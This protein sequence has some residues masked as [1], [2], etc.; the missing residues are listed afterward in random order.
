MILR[1]ILISQCADRELYA[2]VADTIYQYV[3]M[4]PRNLSDINLKVVLLLDSKIK[5]YTKIFS[6]AFAGITRLSSM[7]IQISCQ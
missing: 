5:L 2:L 3:S 6:R 1:G 7:S 4:E